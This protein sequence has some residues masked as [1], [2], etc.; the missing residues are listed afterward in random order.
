MRN[1]DSCIAWSGRDYSSI[2]LI[3]Q[4]LIHEQSGLKVVK[5]KSPVWIWRERDDDWISRITG[6]LRRLCDFVGR[7]G[8]VDEG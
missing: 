5:T 2:P 6:R 7:V 1:T 3:F 4:T 8:L